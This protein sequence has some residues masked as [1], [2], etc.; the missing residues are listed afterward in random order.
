MQDAA[1]RE[2]REETGLEVE[3]DD[4]INVNEQIAEKRILFFTF[5]GR[6]IGG[7]EENNDPKIKQIKWLDIKEAEERM[8]W[9]QDV[10][11]TLLKNS[12]GYCLEIK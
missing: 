12:A 8:P 11:S 6:I 9:Y 5:R 7:K 10:R 1:I 4:L 3:I 2:A